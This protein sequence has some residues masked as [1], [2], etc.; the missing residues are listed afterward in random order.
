MVATHTRKDLR[1]R[2]LRR[3]GDIVIA[4]AT[5]NGTTTTFTDTETFY[6]DSSRYAGR[7]AYF[8]DGT[9]ANLGK[10]RYVQG[11]NGTTQTL[12]FQH[13][14]PA[15]VAEGDEIELTNAYGIGV[16]HDITHEAINWAIS[17][18]RTYAL[19]PAVSD[20]GT[21]DQASTLSL[22][23]SW[24]GVESVHYQH[25]ITDEWHVVERARKHGKRGWAIDHANR[26]LV[27]GGDLNRYLDDT[28]IRVY[29]YTLPDVLEA[30]DDTTT[31]DIEWLVNM[32]TA[33][34]MLDVVR[35]RQGAEWGNQGLYYEDQANRLRA[36]LA[37]VLGPSFTRI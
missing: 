11:Y 23:E 29:G 17:I 27:L 9:A 31:V 21:W 3:F 18:S 6:G 22:P 25:P 20:L 13:A 37:P 34:L 33:H 12:T 1:R 14:L 19:E 4:T 28:T 30:D 2:V 16:T 10:T 15:A 32:A 5:A 8:S 7:H 26:T 35:S 36:R 24:V